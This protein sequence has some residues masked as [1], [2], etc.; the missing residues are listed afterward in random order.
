MKS[1]IARSDPMIQDTLI[2]NA[3]FKTMKIIIHRGTHEIEGAFQ[4]II[5]LR[6]GRVFRVFFPYWLCRRITQQGRQELMFRYKS[7]KITRKEISDRSG[8]IMMMVRPSMLKDLKSIKN[9]EG[10]TFIYSLWEACRD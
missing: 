4:I 3:L 6:A 5:L 1:D 8:E 2:L 9:I 10:A 7:Y